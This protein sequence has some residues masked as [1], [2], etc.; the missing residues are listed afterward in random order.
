MTLQNK[1]LLPLFCSCQKLLF[2]TVHH[3]VTWWTMWLLCSWEEDE[4]N[5][6]LESKMVNAFE[7]VWDTAHRQKIPLRTAAY[8]VALKSVTR[9]TMIRGFD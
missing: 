7:S 4:V 6:K 3:P 1:L 8:V 9:A 5:R 2:V